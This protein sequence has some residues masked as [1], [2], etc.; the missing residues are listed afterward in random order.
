MPDR[1]HHRTVEAHR[2]RFHYR[3]RSVPL[4]FEFYA[5]LRLIRGLLFFFLVKGSLLNVFEKRKRLD[6]ELAVCEDLL[7]VLILGCTVASHFVPSPEIACIRCSRIHPF[8][9]VRLLVSGILCPHIV[10]TTLF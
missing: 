7:R 10:N 1:P 8:K 2:Y 4:R 3:K 5:V 9:T 6:F